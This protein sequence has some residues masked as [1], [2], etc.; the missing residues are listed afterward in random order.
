MG[1]R[2]RADEIYVTIDGL[3]HKV[4]RQCSTPKT[5][6]NFT[7]RNEEKYPFPTNSS[8]LCKSCMSHYNRNRPKRSRGRGINDVRPIISRVVDGV[9]VRPC[10]TCGVEKTAE[11]YYTK[12][13]R[14][15]GKIVWSHTCRSC[16]LPQYKEYRETHKE[17]IK[18]YKLSWQRANREHVNSQAR[19]YRAIPEAWAKRVVVSKRYYC[20]C[21]GLPFGITAEDV[22]AAMPQDGLCPALKVKLVYGGGHKAWADSASVDRLIP[23]LGYVVGNIAIISKRANL[24][25]QDATAQEL[26]GIVDWLRSVTAS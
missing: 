6:D 15:N 5:Y 2:R 20:K 12:K 3:K 11:C 18:G 14:M 1:N 26:Q 19:L 24:I 25:K 4:C 8:D 10:R 22:I 23:E 9:E 13:N 17:L 16:L 7:F 21:L